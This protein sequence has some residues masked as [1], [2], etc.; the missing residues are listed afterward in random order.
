MKAP[1]WLL[2]QDSVLCKLYLYEDK[3]LGTIN[4]VVLAQHQTI[5]LQQPGILKYTLN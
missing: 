1:D 3:T 2:T 4:T 5:L